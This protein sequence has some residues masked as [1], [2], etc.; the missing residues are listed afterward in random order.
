MPKPTEADE[1][2]PERLLSAEEVA[3]RL[4]MGVDWVYAE[5]RRGRIP[6]IKLG[7]Y[8]RY[9][10]SAIDEWLAGIEEAA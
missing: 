9:R 7:R 8:R 5:T 2:D 3:Q 10:S 1:N 4:G 6:H